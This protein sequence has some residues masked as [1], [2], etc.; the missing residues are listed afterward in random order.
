MRKF[1]IAPDSFKECLSAREVAEALSRGIRKVDPSAEIVLQPIADGG[2]GT[3][4]AVSREEER[5]FVTVKGPDQNPV[6]AAYAIRGE[7]AIIEM[8]SA[9][10]LC[11]IPEDKRR[12]VNAT[13]YGVGELIAH[14]SGQGVKHI[15]LT[16]GGSATNDGGCGML[17]ALGAKFL[18]A[19]GS[20]FLPT[21]GTLSEIEQIDTRDLLLTQKDCRFTVATDVQNP[22]LGEKGATRMFARQKGATDA[23]LDEMEVGM[24]HYAAVL[25]KTAGRSV[26]QI[27]GAGAAGG[28][29][30]PLLA[31]ADAGIVSGID[32]V[33]SAVG[34]YEATRGADAILTGEG[35]IDRQSLLGKAISGVVRA[36]GEIPVYAFVGCVGDPVGQLLPLGI[37]QIYAV[38]EIAKSDADSKAN[39]KD[40]LQKLAERFA[41]ENQTE[42]PVPNCELEK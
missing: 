30:V 29:A 35:K 23:E 4:E 19:D 6:R 26:A 41:D 42:K 24:A 18:R 21:G 28:L 36:A 38:R 9:A 2:E 31:F 25:E 1:V 12:V 16:A 37:K 22:L 3:L 10:G 39:A 33:L 5:I 11:L 13:T 15:L 27:A 8:A 40:Y 7:T 32:A 20:S 34:F 14:A 17:A